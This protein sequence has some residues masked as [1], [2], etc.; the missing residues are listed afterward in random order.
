VSPDE[1][2]QKKAQCKESRMI[3]LSDLLCI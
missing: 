2:M 1:I 3:K